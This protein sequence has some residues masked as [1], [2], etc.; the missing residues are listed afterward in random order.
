MHV[1][2]VKMVMLMIVP[3]TTIAVIVVTTIG[4]AIAVVS[5]TVVVMKGMSSQSHFNFRVFPEGCMYVCM[6]VD[7][8]LHMCIYIYIYYCI[9]INNCIHPH[10]AR[11]RLV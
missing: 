5:Y 4:C 11:R 8:I 3:T 10:Q 7:C 2:N 6:S 1:R 9:F